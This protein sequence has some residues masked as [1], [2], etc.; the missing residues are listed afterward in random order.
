MTRKNKQS[1][2][3]MEFQDKAVRLCRMP[4]RSIA[5]VALELKIPAWKLR[6]WIKN[7]EEK[8]ERDSELTEIIR[9]E[10]ELKEAREEIE[11][12]KKAAAYFAKSQK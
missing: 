11:I 10:N 9:L 8:L 12:L 1:E 2:Y 3:S 4:G 6:T 5:S 7:S